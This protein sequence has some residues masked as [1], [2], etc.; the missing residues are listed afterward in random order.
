M[1]MAEATAIGTVKSSRLPGGG[2]FDPRRIA[3]LDPSSSPTTSRFS[4][5]ASDVRVTRVGDGDVGI[6][7]ASDGGGFLVLSENAYP[8]WRARVDGAE[9]PI[10]RADVTMQGVVVPAGIHRVDFAM[11]SRSLRTGMIVSG[12]AALL[13]LGLLIL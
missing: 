12:V 5:G 9:V 3:L 11:E 6:R 8:G 2:P 1:T 7:V 13:C 4:P 10:Y